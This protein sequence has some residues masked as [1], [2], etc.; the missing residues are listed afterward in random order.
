MNVMMYYTSPMRNVPSFITLA[1]CFCLLGFQTSG[2]HTHVDERGY[3]GTPQGT[4]FHGHSHHA[5]G[6][7]HADNGIV[8][9]QNHLGDSDYAGDKDVSV[10]D[11]GL[12][13]SKISD[14]LIYLGFC[15]FIATKSI[16]RY[17]SNHLDSH[18]DRHR[19]HRWPQLRAPPPSSYPLSH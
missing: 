10:F 3:V 13:A 9:G 7:E 18:P 11:L 17:S 2:L 8:D 1:A 4:H 14:F 5:D 19:E 6:A 12:G 15:L 16:Y